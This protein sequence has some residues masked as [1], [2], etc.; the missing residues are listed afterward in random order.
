VGGEGGGGGVVE[1]EVELEV[2]VVDMKNGDR[3]Q[4]IG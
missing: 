2:E 4:I 1:V 3:V